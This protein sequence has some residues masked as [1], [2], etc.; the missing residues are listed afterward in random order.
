MKSVISILALSLTAIVM[1]SCKDQNRTESPDTIPRA[2]VDSLQ[3]VMDQVSTDSLNPELWKKQ[4]QL[5]L[6]RK[7]TLKAMLSLRRYNYLAPEDGDGW[8]EMAWLLANK[9]DPGV[10]II[11]DSL[12]LVKDDMIRTKAR[13]I[14]G[15][16]YSNIQQDDMALREFDSTIV[17]NYTFID[18]YIEKGIILYDRKKFKEA[19]STFQQAFKIVNNNPELYYWIGKC[20]EG[21]GNKTEAAD[22]QKKYEALQ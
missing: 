8:V 19:L 2:K 11:T 20:Y 17:H 7:D 6:E 13:Y 21:L 16:Y 12:A 3:L 4:Y 5:F 18:A 10:L 15:L 1:F 9:K 14:R 22:W